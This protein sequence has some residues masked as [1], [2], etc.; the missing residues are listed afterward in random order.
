MGRLS[1]T[2]A[3]DRAT[4]TEI[5][6]DPR[7]IIG[8]VAIVV[9]ATVLAGLGGLLWTQWG[10]RTPANA[11]YET[12]IHRFIIRS[13][14]LGGLIQI[15]MWVA[16]VLVTYAYL[17]AFGVPV[18]VMRLAR[19]LGW[20]FAP[21]ALELFVFPPGLEFAAGVIALGYAFATMTAAVQAAAKTTP[22]RAAVSALAGFALLAI[23]LSL[24]G[25]GV[26]D[27]APGIFALD[28]QPISVGIRTLP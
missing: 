28:P 5:A 10:G 24:L 22:G 12:D 27:L 19:A 4:L 15:G 26:T 6:D 25:N 14:V 17:A 9:V 18:S 16:L 2:L 21:V 20:A 7:A 1:G 13:V 23:V 3:L 11:I 8:A